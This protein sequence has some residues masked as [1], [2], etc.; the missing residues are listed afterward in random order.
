MPT[1]TTGL[2]SLYLLEAARD[3]APSIDLVTH[4]VFQ[5]EAA[6]CRYAIRYV[7]GRLAEINP[8]GLDAYLFD[9]A[10]GDF[11]DDNNREAIYEAAK[12]N[13]QALENYLLALP[14]A[15]QYEAIASYFDWAD[16]DDMAAACIITP[17]EVESDIVVS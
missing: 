16:C 6:A 3:N 9:L 4:K 2:Y 1:S 12:E 15:K 17:L 14:L 11:I 13:T 5:G 10:L 8:D 7:A